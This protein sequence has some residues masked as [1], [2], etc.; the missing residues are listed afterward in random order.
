MDLGNVV[1]RD[2]FIRPDDEEPLCERPRKR[3]G[4]QGGEIDVVKG[5]DAASNAPKVSKI[6]PLSDC[7]QTGNVFGP[8]LGREP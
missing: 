2:V 7:N 5:S 1:G 6:Y 3:R 8:T 4:T